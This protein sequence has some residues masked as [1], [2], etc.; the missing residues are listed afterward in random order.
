MLENNHCH[1]WH[2]SLCAISSNIKTKITRAVQIN[3]SFNESQSTSSLLFIYGNDSSNECRHFLKYKI[4][5]QARTHHNPPRRGQTEREQGWNWLDF[6][7]AE[8]EINWTLYFVKY[9]ISLLTVKSSLAVFASINSY[10]Y[11]S[12]GFCVCHDFSHCSEQG[13]IS[14]SLWPMMRHWAV[15]GCVTFY[16]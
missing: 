8:L 9:V 13:I 7:P 14:V 16:T 12:R 3:L 11:N 15:T 4:K 1:V 5:S 10:T 2:C 6:P